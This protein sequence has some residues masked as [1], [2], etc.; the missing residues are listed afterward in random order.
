VAYLYFLIKDH[1]FV[2]GNKRIA[3]LSFFVICELNNL[4]P[5]YKNF[6]IDELAVLIERH[7]S[8]KHQEVIYRIKS[9]LF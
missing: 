6:L 9:I 4:A 7:K 8:K 5:D 2:D 1:P 3:C